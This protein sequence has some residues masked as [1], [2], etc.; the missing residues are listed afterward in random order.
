M[1]PRNFITS[2]ALRIVL[3]AEADGKLSWDNF[4]IFI[5]LEVMFLS[6]EIAVSDLSLVFVSSSSSHNI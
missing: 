3:E 5:N 2:I 6:K 1:L 4:S